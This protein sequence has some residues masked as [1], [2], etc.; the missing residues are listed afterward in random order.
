MP[1]D[2]RAY[3]STARVVA[4]TKPPADTAGEGAPVSRVPRRSTTRGRGGVAAVG[5]ASLILTPLAA[6]RLSTILANVLREH[7]R[8]YGPLDVE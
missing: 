3:P 7:E 8:R 1:H 5:V 4:R 2:E 6:K